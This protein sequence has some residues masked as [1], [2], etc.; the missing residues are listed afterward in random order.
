MDA[1]KNICDGVPIFFLNEGFWVTCAKKFLVDL[2]GS[3][4]VFEII[5]ASLTS[6]NSRNVIKSGCF[7]KPLRWKVPNFFKMKEELK[8]SCVK[9]L[10]FC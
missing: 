3:Q 6:N 7:E 10:R 8:V 1:S 5:H 9:K 4:Y 2:F